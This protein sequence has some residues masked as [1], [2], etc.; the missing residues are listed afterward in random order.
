[1][2]QVDWA[3]AQHLLNP[4]SSPFCGVKWL[5]DCGF[6]RVLSDKTGIRR[7]MFITTVRANA[8]SWL[9]CCWAPSQPLLSPS[10]VPSLHC[11]E[12]IPKIGKKYSQKSNCAAT[13]PISTFMYLWSIYIF[14]WSICLL[15]CRKY[16]DRSWEN[17]N[18]S[19]THECGNWDWGR[20]IPRKGIHKWDFRCS[21][22]WNCFMT[23]GFDLTYVFR[24]VVL[25]VMPDG[26]GEALLRQVRDIR[27]EHK[28]EKRDTNP[29]SAH[30]W[31]V[32][33]VT[34]D[35]TGAKLLVWRL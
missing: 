16:V 26:D 15:C 30:L 6:W 34:D 25:V 31:N 28:L 7:K 20:A 13:V 29:Y 8:A 35:T 1:M 32:L 27:H 19:Q 23:M 5:Y 10:Q 4:F 2:R 12:P 33:Q 21:V 17:I 22:G 18:R 11:K 3:A 9:S 14:P 24:L